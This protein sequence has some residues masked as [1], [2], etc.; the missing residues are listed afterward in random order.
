M[1]KVKLFLFL[2]VYDEEETRQIDYEK[3]DRLSFRIVETFKWCV[4]QTQHPVQ[5]A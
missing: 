2:F 3:I 4:N 5:M 1:F